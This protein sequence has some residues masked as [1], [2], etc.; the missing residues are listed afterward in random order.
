MPSFPGTVFVSNLRR[1]NLAN[2]LS[3]WIQSISYHGAWYRFLPSNKAPEDRLISV[4]CISNTLNGQPDLPDGDVLLHAGD[5]TVHGTF[6]ELQAQL[7]W[8][9]SQPHKYKILIAGERDALLDPMFTNRHPDLYPFAVGRTVCDLQFGSVIYLRDSSVTLHFPAIGR[10]IAIHGSP[11]ISS[12]NIAPFHVSRD[13]NAWAGTVP[14]GTDVLLTHEP[15]WQILDGHLQ[16]GSLYLLREIERVKPSLVVCGHVHSGYGQEQICFDYK[17]PSPSPL[18]AVPP[19]RPTGLRALISD[20]WTKFVTTYPSVLPGFI[21][22][23][24]EQPLEDDETVTTLINA[25]LMDP[26]DQDEDLPANKPI[27]THI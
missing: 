24:Q 6:E 14:A 21:R 12:D 15:P 9:S 3:H 5:L 25:S 19:E 26:E 13:Q 16:S 1:F 17:L 22:R 10:E 4:V 7:T 18:E 8:L 20:T 11:N 27:V 23:K 2:V